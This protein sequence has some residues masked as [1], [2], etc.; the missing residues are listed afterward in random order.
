MENNNEKSGF[1]YTYSAKERKEVE[2][3]RKR[4]TAEEKPSEN[5]I[6]RLRRLD[7][8]VT[9]K[10]TAWALVIGILGALVLGTGMSFIMTEIGN[11]LGVW[12]IVLGVGIGIIGMALCAIS[13]PVYSY[14]L[15][16]G[17]KKIAPEM[18]RLTDE[19]LK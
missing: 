19:L 15:E 16:R 8:E 17:R 13:Y 7:R 6:E 12:S 4:Y 2:E 10:A 3:I 1:V 5:A 9:N 18:I 14:V 11:V